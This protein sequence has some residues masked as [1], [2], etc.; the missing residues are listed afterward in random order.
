MYKVTIAKAMN[1]YIAEVGCQTLVF[2]TEGKLINELTRY[3]NNPDGVE[4]EYQ[5]LYGPKK[6]EPATPR[7]GEIGL[8]VENPSVPEPTRGVNRAFDSDG[9]DRVSLASQ[10]HL[11]DN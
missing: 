5:E 3:M 10:S 11:P 2:E 8:R 6:N 7:G 9:D 1:G 4:K